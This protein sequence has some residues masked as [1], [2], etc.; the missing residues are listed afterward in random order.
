MTRTLSWPL[1]VM[2]CSVPSIV[3]PVPS[4]IE[5][6]VLFSSMVPSTLKV[7]LSSP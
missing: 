1:T 5:G 4:V 3:S 7:M 6:R 2:L